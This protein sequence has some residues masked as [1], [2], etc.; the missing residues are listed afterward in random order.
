[1]D[2][3]L[4]SLLQRLRQLLF[5]VNAWMDAVFRGMGQPA[6]ADL[7]RRHTTQ[8]KGPHQDAGQSPPPRYMPQRFLIDRQF[9]GHAC[10][11]D[12]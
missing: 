4:K 1:M 2:M 3:A 11:T 8:K 6:A 7:Q 9:R 10:T 5:L 12:Q